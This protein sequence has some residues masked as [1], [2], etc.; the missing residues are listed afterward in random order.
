M[1]I[2]NK[3]PDEVK[4]LKNQIFHEGYKP[5]F[6]GHETFPMRY[7]WLKK[8]YD[9]V[10]ETDQ[11]KDNRYIFRE[12]D[13]IARFGV[14]KNMVAS[15]RHWG[16]ATGVLTED[17]RAGIIKTT[18][19]GQLIFGNKKQPGY[20]PYLEDPSTLWLLHWQLSS[21]PQ[22]TTWYWAFNHY[23][24]LNFDRTQLVD[25]IFRIAHDSQ[26]KKTSKA[27]IKRDVECFVRSYVPHQ[28]SGKK[29]LEDTLE[30]PLTEL[31]LIKNVGKRD[32]FRFVVGSKP[33]LS[34]GVFIYALI[35]FWLSSNYKD[36]NQ[37]PFDIIA[38][39]PGSPGRVFL[40]DEND[41]AERLFRI[42]EISKGALEWSETSGI[43]GIIK[44][45]NIGYK[46]NILDYLALD[47]N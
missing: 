30:S 10:N 34:D 15:I 6:S 24:G 42:K 18:K 40:L 17:Q 19:L 9:A 5:Q 25:R 47:H 37:L 20:D 2:W 12:D 11:T 29:S 44:R 45:P 31:G 35:S 22:K 28:I 26:W 38:R 33:T 14:G 27:T 32:G 41:L 4:M 21:S 8:A 36:L 3:L 23:P 46:K 43:K 39:S 16:A 7:G 13:A 1:S